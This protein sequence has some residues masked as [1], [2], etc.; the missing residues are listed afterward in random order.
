[1]CERY[2]PARQ[3]RLP[4]VREPVDAYARKTLLRCW[5]NERRR[6]WRRAE[7]RDGLVP[8]TPQPDRDPAGDAHL[9]AVMRQALGADTL[10]ELNS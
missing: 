10:E 1:M 2:E 4:R 3:Q 5:L 8:D 6:P 9:K 7:S